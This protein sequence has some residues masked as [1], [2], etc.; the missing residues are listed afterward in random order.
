MSSESSCGKTS[1]LVAVWYVFSAF[2]AFLA[3]IPLT[4]E[5]PLVRQAQ[6]QHQSRGGTGSRTPAEPPFRGHL[7]GQQRGLPGCRGAGSHG[8]Q[9]Q[10]GRVHAHQVPSV[11]GTS[12]SNEDG[13]DPC[14][15]QIY[16]VILPEVVGRLSNIHY[17]RTSTSGTSGM[18]LRSPG[19]TGT[20]S[21]GVSYR[22]SSLSRVRVLWN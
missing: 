15:R 1:C 10:L 22:Q 18:G 11:S 19:R 13:A 4:G 14:S 7:S 8:L 6:R 3:W 12:A 21:R 9:R 2:S 17:H 16:E 5:V 20:S